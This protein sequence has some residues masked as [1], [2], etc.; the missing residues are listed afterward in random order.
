MFLGVVVLFIGIILIV[1]GSVLGTEKGKVEVGFGGF[2][3]PIPFGWAS[4]PKMLKWI[5]LASVVF[6]VGFILLFVLNRF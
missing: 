3:G 4:D 6:F 5:I 1:L 2:I